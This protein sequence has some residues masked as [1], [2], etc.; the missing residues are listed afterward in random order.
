MAVQHGIWKIGTTP[1]ALTPIRLD[2]E[3][4]LE[5]QIFKDISI[6]NANWLL[7]GRQVQTDFGKYIDLLAIDAS[8][9]IIVIELKKHKT[10]RDVVAQTIDY[11]AW[12]ET[13]A[14][15]RIVQI[16]NTYAERW[17]VAEKSFNNAFR[18][19]FGVAPTE[20]D[21]NSSHQLVIVA[22]ELDAS[23]ERIITYLNNKCSI[24][25]NAVFF[26]VFA[27]GDNQYLSRAWM[28]DPAE[29][30]EHAIQMDPKQDWNGEFYGS[31]GASPETYHWEDARQHGFLCAGGGRWYS[32]TLF[33]LET[34]NRVWVNIPRVGYVGVAQVLER[35]K[36]ADDFITPALQL[37][38]H[39]KKVAD[40]GEDNADYFVPVRW[41]HE[42]PQN[43]AINEIGLFGNQNSIARPRTPKW[44]YT[45]NRLK[46]IWKLQ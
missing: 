17:G 40:V 42:L 20:D 45:V 6:L 13:L 27:D 8:G 36:P 34:G 29:T 41:L 38:G 43:Q 30:A 1:Q 9:S 22:A 11:A 14:S 44:D 25:V 16:Y 4:L 10:P 19:K 46:E 28:I 31:F 39:Y 33:M 7:I 12:V 24:G 5:E 2:T 37:T 21:I 35:A 15:E 32:K 3:Q 23:T 18:A 26:S